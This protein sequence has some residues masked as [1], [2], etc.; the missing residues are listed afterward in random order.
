MASSRPW[1]CS[2]DERGSAIA[3]R[4]VAPS[5]S[6]GSPFISPRARA[7][8]AGEAFVKI[9][10]TSAGSNFSWRARVADRWISRSW[11]CDRAPSYL[12]SSSSVWTTA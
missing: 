11:R 1:V 7:R 12:R 10:L 9:A 4:I 6:D 5:A 8:A 2:L 3:A